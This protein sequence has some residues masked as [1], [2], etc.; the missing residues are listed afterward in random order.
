MIRVKVNLNRELEKLQ[1]QLEEEAKLDTVIAQG[2]SYLK[3]RTPK[4]TGEA[5][6][7]WVFKPTP[8]NGSTIGYYYNDEDYIVYLN[9]GSSEQAPSYFI[10]GE[11]AKIGKLIF[12]VVEE[13]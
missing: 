6:S 8:N 10:E 11:L 1:K 12:P 9:R 13:T 3:A 7:S 2:L 5:S 4:D